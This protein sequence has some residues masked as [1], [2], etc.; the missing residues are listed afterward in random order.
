MDSMMWRDSAGQHGGVAWQCLGD[1]SVHIGKKDIFLSEFINIGG[2]LSGVPVTAEMVCT[3]GIYADE[4][5]ISDVFAGSA[6]G[7]Q[8]QTC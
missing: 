7:K 6:A 3:T 8:D 5:Y 4:D 1:G 2:C